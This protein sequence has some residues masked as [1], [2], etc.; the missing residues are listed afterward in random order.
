MNR[1]TKKFQHPVVNTV[2]SISSAVVWNNHPPKCKP[3]TCTVYASACYLTIL[4]LL[5]AQLHGCLYWMVGNLQYSI[6]V[7]NPN[8][9][10]VYKHLVCCKPTVFDSDIG[11][12][13]KQTED[14]LL[15]RYKHFFHLMIASE[16]CN[17]WKICFI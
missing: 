3:F 16:H 4:L 12:G 13:V 10:N 5:Y 2:S 14:V 11:T 7:E 8:Y 6:F 1:A 9:K 17:Y 15:R